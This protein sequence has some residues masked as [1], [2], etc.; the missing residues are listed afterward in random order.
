MSG[1]QFDEDYKSFQRDEN[2]IKDVKLGPIYSYKDEYGTELFEKQRYEHKYDVDKDGKPKKGFIQRSYP[3]VSGYGDIDIPRNADGTMRKIPGRHGGGQVLYHLDKIAGVRSDTSITYVMVEGEKD[4]DN[5]QK[6]LG[7]AYVVTTNSDGGDALRGDG[8]GNICRSFAEHGLIVFHDE[9]EVGYQWGIT[10][11]QLIDELPVEGRPKWVKIVDLPDMGDGGDVTDY[12]EGLRS[13]GVGDAGIA[14][15]IEKM[16]KDRGWDG[17]QWIDTKKAKSALIKMEIKRLAAMSEDDFDDEVDDVARKLGLSKTEIKKKIKSIG[18]GGGT[19]VAK[20]IKISD[21]WVLFCD[22]EGNEWAYINDVRSKECVM[23][24]EKG[25]KACDVLVDSFYKLNRRVPS[26]ES[27][28]DSIRTL[29]A[30]ARIGGIVEDPELRVAERIEDGKRTIYYDMCDGSGSV[31]KIDKDGW[32]VT[33][34][35]HIKFARPNGT[36]SS[37]V[38]RRVEVGEATKQAVLK[39][40]KLMIYQRRADFVLDV[41]WFLNFFRPDNVQVLAYIPGSEGSAKSTATKI[42][43][44]LLDP[45][46]LDLQSMPAK[47]DDIMIACKYRRIQAFDNV[48]EI[49]NSVSDVLCK[50]M[51]GAGMSKRELY[52]S[53]GEVVLK[54]KR[55]MIING[56]GNPIK[57]PDLMERAIVLRFEPIPEERRKAE[58][59]S[60]G[61]WEAFGNVAG[62]IFGGLLN[63]VVGGLS[64]EGTLD[65]GTIPRLADFAKWSMEC[66]GFGLDTG[67]FRRAFEE[68]AKDNT[69]DLFDSDVVAG[70]IWEVL[71]GVDDVGVNVF[72]D[73]DAIDGATGLFKSWTFGSEWRV[74]AGEL[75]KMM[76]DFAREREME[77]FREREWPRDATRLG[78]RIDRLYNVFKS[79]GILIRKMKS[80]GN[81]LIEFVKWRVDLSVVGGTDLSSKTW[82]PWDDIV[83]MKR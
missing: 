15:M 72:G 18:G 76:N 43:R 81:R 60:G 59:G 37:V 12:I 65:Y 68:G 49:R 47:E 70:V 25:G 1:S 61:I 79:K 20:L 13:S 29:Q 33:D 32:R 39:L 53:V 83:E 40:K 64:V 36:A 5:L 41:C 57:R 77:V 24:D 78:G 54:A 35:T 82:D 10:L 75:L 34:S 46:V 2:W 7:D 23:L 4:A 26:P 44:N 73:G 67:D 9:D 3:A 21:P 51:T 19:D 14:S 71:T 58:N 66:E 27:I 38:P 45:N 17:A 56:I 42:H 80:N 30:K 69:Q 74:S 55:P 52:S 48:S 50:V 6:I 16:I 31:I 62:E 28:R 11:L 63:M 8:K 22:S